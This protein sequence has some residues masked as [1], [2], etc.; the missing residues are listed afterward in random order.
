MDVGAGRAYI[1]YQTSYV[2]YFILRRKMVGF[3]YH[4]SSAC[5]GNM[6][7]EAGLFFKVDVE[8]F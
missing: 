2:V 8:L 4:E 3:K 1:G 6:E 7:F 5:C